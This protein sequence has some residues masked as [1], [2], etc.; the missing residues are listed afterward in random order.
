MVPRKSGLGG[1][2][3]PRSLRAERGLEWGGAQGPEG[4]CYH[5]VGNLKTHRTVTN[6]FLCD[7]RL[8]VSFSFLVL[9]KFST[10]IM[11]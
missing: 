3:E 7:V 11:Y 9:F 6:D 10:V 2:G 4:G 5:K 8:F 1:A